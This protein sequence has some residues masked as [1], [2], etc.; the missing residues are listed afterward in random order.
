V[1][2]PSVF[3]QTWCKTSARGLGVVSGLLLG[4]CARSHP[5]VIT[6][7]APGYHESPPLIWAIVNNHPNEALSMIRAGADPNTADISPAL[8][9][10][11]ASPHCM[12]AVV[13]ALVEGGAK[14]DA[15][16]IGGETPLHEACSSGCPTVVEYLISKGADISAREQSGDTPLHIAA[17]CGEFPSGTDEIIR[18]LMTHGA[19]VNAV[20]ARGDTPL[21]LATEAG[22]TEGAALLKLHGAKRAKQLSHPTTLSQ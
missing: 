6:T 7:T 15:R 14:V 10:A 16:G 18:I 13:Q 22:W 4:A 8:Y 19:D 2:M 5:A 3:F 9:Y 1:E 17:Y 21:D 11:A 12:L 20:D